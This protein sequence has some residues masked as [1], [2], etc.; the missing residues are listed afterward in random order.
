MYKALMA[1]CEDDISYSDNIR[2][3]MYEIHE[4]GLHSPEQR[5]VYLGK[6]F[7]RKFTELPPDASHVDVCDYIIK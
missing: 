6:T 1:G 3:M 2:N 4:E 5:K 7:R